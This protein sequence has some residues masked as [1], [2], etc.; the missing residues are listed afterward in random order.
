MDTVEGF[1]LARIVLV[2]RKSPLELLFEKLGT[3]TQAEFYLQSRGQKLSD[4]EEA[5][6]RFEMGLQSVLQQLP[7]A[8]RRTRVDRFQLDRFL[9]APDDIVVFVGQ[10]GLVAN[11]AKY[12]RGQLA[13]GIN[14]DPS[15]YEGVLVPHAPA[16]LTELIR[17]ADLTGAGSDA[18]KAFFIEHRTMVEATREDGQSLLALNE[19]YIGH[20]THQSSKYRIQV[21]D[22]VERHSSSGV[23]V[24]T[25]TGATGWARSISTPLRDAPALPTPEASQ[26]AFFVR[27][28]WPSVA[29]GTDLVK[30]LVG[31]GESLVLHSDLP[32]DGLAF[33]DGIESDP[34]EFL[35]G[36]SLTIKVSDVRL[37]LVKA[38]P[39]PPKPAA[40]TPSAAAPEDYDDRDMR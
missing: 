30:G 6:M 24:A 31:E 23:I 8:R 5:H 1:Q 19:I 28:A 9:F 20:R 15:R 4:Y 34:I 37:R 2:T 22:K 36:Q 16:R 26:I 18:G 13:I 11:A 7:A 32:E 3:R 39:P 29:T 12:L 38:V 27:E 33:G 14:P 10:D 17:F 35:S 21:G 25:G 40:P